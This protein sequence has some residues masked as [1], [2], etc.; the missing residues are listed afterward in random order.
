M[1]G[2][3]GGRAV[4]TV[5]GVHW[6]CQSQDAGAKNY[7]CRIVLK[8]TPAVVQPNIISDTSL[9]RTPYV[10]VHNSPVSKLR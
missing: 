9:S 8:I 5:F 7:H 6:M 2:S 10:A 1:E 4:G 3:E